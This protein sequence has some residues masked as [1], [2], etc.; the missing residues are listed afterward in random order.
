MK[1]EM[2]EIIEVFRPTEKPEDTVALHWQK[3]QGL[4]RVALIV[5]GNIISLKEGFLIEKR[6][7]PKS[8][9]DQLTQ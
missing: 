8:E 6:H 3:Q 2:V 1:E 9:A 4:E 7:F 5:G